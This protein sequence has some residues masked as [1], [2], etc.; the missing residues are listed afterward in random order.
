[1]CFVQF[2][3]RT[4]SR[5]DGPRKS[6]NPSLDKRTSLHWSVRMVETVSDHWAM[7]LGSATVGECDI[8]GI[9]EQTLPTAWSCRA[10]RRSG[11][12]GLSCE[13][14]LGGLREDLRRQ[15]NAKTQEWQC[16]CPWE[17]SHGQQS[18]VHD[19][20][21]REPEREEDG[22]TS[23]GNQS[24]WS[25]PESGSLGPTEQRS[26]V[27][28]SADPHEGCLSVRDR[29]A[30]FCSWEWGSSPNWSSSTGSATVF[31]DSASA[32]ALA[33]PF[34]HDAVNWNGR[35]FNRR[36]TRRGFSTWSSEWLFNIGTRE[37][38]SVTTWNDAPAKYNLHF[39]LPRRS[40]V[41]RARLPRN[42]F[43][44]RKDTGCRIG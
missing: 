38:W 36:R 12:H 42:G 30:S 31:R 3:R 4:A 11:A 33:V 24:G 16:D 2:S 41:V 1:M 44:C 8:L 40:R 18:D 32:T 13:Q 19:R 22:V 39:G 10:N 15:N 6:G 37:R 29:C 14:C 7:I 21:K 17:W 5:W 43:P 20:S 26:E 25:R 34:R 23:E 27:R 35:I 28:Q 9:G